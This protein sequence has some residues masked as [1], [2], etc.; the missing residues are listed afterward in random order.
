MDVLFLGNHTVGLTVLQTLSSVSNIVG[1]IAHPSDPE[2]G[3]RYPS[4]YQWAMKMNLPSVRGRPEDKSIHNFVLEKAPDVIWI[5]DYRYLL[6]QEI[7][8]I[9][10]LGTI[11]MHPSLLPAYRGRAPINWAIINGEERL[12]LTVHFVDAGT[13]TGD[14]I[15][16]EGYLLGDCEDVGDALNKLYPIYAKLTEKTVRFFNSG[17]VPRQ[18]QNEKQA[19]YFPAR[20]PEDGI[21]N[22]EQP[23]KNIR[24]LIRAVASPYPGAFTFI[25]HEKIFIWKAI[26]CED[27]YRHGVSGE[28]VAIE[29]GCPIVQCGKGYLRLC[30]YNS[31]KTINLKLSDGDRFLSNEEHKTVSMYDKH[32]RVHGESYLAL[33]WGSKKSQQ[34]RFKILSEIGNL[35]GSTILDV[36]CGLGHF[37]DWLDEQNIRVDYTGLDITPALLDKANE[38]RSDLHFVHGSIFDPKLFIGKKFNFVFASGIFTTYFE[39]SDSI[40]KSAIQNMWKVVDIGIAFN[41]LSSWQTNKEPGEFYG[42]PLEMLMFCRKLSPWVVLRHDY[43][44]GDFTI[45]IYKA[46][47][48]C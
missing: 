31:E 17:I 27:S 42:D 29:G 23:V 28:I 10:R 7:L 1:V 33:N 12:G 38:R 22:W 14:I 26:I 30:S 24:D 35:N 18:P 41:S 16:Q 39:R 11:N 40:F 19:S 3:V 13:D 6:P 37:A 45:Y 34:I 5:T 4:V 15:V 48:S 2:D 32:L 43:H 21:I 36:G 47:K 9:P 44:P 25:H 8:L 46:Q 20:R